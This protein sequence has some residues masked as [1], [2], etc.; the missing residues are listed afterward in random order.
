MT[1]PSVPSIP[2]FHRRLATC[3]EPLALF[4]AL[5][6]GEPLAFLYES[7]EAHGQRG[8][9]SFIG[10]RPREVLQIHE[11]GTATLETPDG[12]RTLEYDDPLALIDSLL[13]RDTMAK[14]P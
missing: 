7:L 8:R 5:Y 11:G 3:A 6:G 12:T 2:A 14:L 13:G 4:E 9:Y 10:A 1:L